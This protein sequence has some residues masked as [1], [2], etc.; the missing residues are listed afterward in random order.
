[1]RSIQSRAVK[2]AKP[3][4]SSCRNK[5]QVCSNCS[6]SKEAYAYKGCPAGYP[7]VCSVC[8][9]EQAREVMLALR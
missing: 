4:K 3:K 7:L 5:L 9:R 6:N 2:A 8:R 1:M